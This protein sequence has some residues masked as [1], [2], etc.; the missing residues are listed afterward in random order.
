MANFHFFFNAQIKWTAGIASS[1]ASLFSPLPSASFLSPSY[2][3][4]PSLFDLHPQ[5]GP[6]FGSF[7]GSSPVPSTNFGSLSRIFTT[8]STS[9]GSLGLDHLHSSHRLWTSRLWTIFFIIRFWIIIYTTKWIIFI[10]IIWIRNPVLSSA[11]NFGSHSLGILPL[12]QPVS[13]P[14]LLVSFA[15]TKI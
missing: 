15:S 9:F 12:L 5:L 2:S 7:L 10:F 6:S 1:Y 4:G 3:S 11:S 13:I 8:S 14:Q